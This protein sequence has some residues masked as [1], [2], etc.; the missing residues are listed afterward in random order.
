MCFEILASVTFLTILETKLRF[1]IGVENRGCSDPT[2]T[3]SVVDEQLACYLLATL[4]VEMM[5]CTYGRLQGP[6]FHQHV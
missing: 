3:S 6:E 4:T 5:C 2:M 1:E